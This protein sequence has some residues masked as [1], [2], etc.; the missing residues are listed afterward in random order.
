[1][2]QKLGWSEGQGLGAKGG[3]I[4]E[5]VN[6]WVLLLLFIIVI[7]ILQSNIVFILYVYCIH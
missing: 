1:M 6:K 4:V 5:P 2:L 3:G 7:F